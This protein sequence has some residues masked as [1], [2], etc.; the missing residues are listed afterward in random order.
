MSIQVKRFILAQERHFLRP[1][2]YFPRVAGDRIFLWDLS[3]LENAFVFPLFSKWRN[4]IHE[5]GHSLDQKKQLVSTYFSNATAENGQ[6]SNP[7]S[8]CF[9]FSSV[10]MRAARVD[11]KT[12]LIIR[13]VR[14]WLAVGGVLWVWVSLLGI[15]RGKCKVKLCSEISLWKGFGILRYW[16]SE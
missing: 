9:F 14:R 15:R 5:E 2:H 13:I 11:R 1:L 3:I 16:Q 6:F 4:E 10:F 8:S 12:G 7:R